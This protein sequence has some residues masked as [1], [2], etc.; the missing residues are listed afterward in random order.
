MITSIGSPAE[1]T[2]IPAAIAACVNI[3]AVV[4]EQKNLG[5]AV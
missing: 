3:G 5:F 1:N 2:V 4:E